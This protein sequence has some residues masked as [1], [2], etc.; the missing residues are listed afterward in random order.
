MIS[1][2][3]SAEDADAYLGWGNQFKGGVV[4]VGEC[5]YLDCEF[6]D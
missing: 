5:E 4:R 3:A 2:S 1:G 6:L